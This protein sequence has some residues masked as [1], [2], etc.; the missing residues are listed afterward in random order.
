MKPFYYLLIAVAVVGGAL[1]AFSALKKD[2]AVDQPTLNI[3][4]LK[5]PEELIAKAKGVVHGQTTA[6]V[7]IM[8]FA[9]YMC[10][11]CGHFTN[12]FEPLI[13][14]DYLNTGKAYEVFYDFPLGGA[15]IHSFLAARAARCA[16]DQG[17][18]WE[19]HDNLFAKQA[20]W[21]Y[22]KTA[23]VGTLKKYATDLGL[24]AGKFNACLDSD[25]HADVVTYNRQLGIA[26]G[27]G[28]T[29][30]VFINGK[31]SADPLNWEVLQKE[32]DAAVG[33]TTK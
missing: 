31:A 13:R 5:T 1:I 27:V 26:A 16:E 9:D 33:S 28:S 11:G 2:K 6:P 30:T 21:S 22:E 19:Y 18:F 7:K 3:A 10:P 24:D 17:K 23:P 32:L 25:M 14:A 29:P 4:E 20:N 8:V 15:H 12:A